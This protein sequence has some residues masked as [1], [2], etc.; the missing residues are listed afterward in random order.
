MP[1]ASA[2]SASLRIDKWL[3]CVRLFK[4]RSV[5]AEAVKSGHVRLNGARVKAAREV[6]VGD[7]MTVARGDVEI[8]ITVTAIPA[9]RGPAAEAAL[10]YEEAPESVAR[11]EQAAAA[12]A[13]LR[14][15]PPT[16]GRPDKRTRRLLARLRGES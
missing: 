9:R 4:T 6:K 15:A 13:A 7:G 3:W 14:I 8:E 5:A 16:Q 11:R 10:C 1:T 12:R 2:T